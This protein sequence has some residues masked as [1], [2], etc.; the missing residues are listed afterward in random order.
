MNV[1]PS[2]HRPFEKYYDALADLLLFAVAFKRGD[3]IRMIIDFDYRDVAR[4][5]AERAY[6]G[7]ALYVQLDY[8]DQFMQA[9]AIRG[10]P[11]TFW[12]PESRQAKL[13]EVTSPGWKLISIRSEAEGDVFEGLPAER[14]TAFFRAYRDNIAIHSDAVMSNRI[15]WT[16]TYLPSEWVVRKAF[17]NLTPE[18]GMTR[19]WNAIV[20]I[21][22]LDADDPREFWRNE[23][24]AFEKRSTFME[25]LRADALHFS[26]PGTDLTVGLNHSARW[27]GGYDRAQSGEEFLA[28][29]PTGEIFTSPDCRRVNGR[30]KFTRPFVMHQNLGE[31]PMDAWLEFRDGRVVD[32]GASRGKDTLAAFF[33]IDDRARYAG[34]I[35]LVDPAS[36]F[37]ETGIT[38]YNGLYDENSACHLAL[39]RAYP[40]TL[41]EE[42]ERSPDELLGMG[43]NVATVHEDA[44]IGGPEVDVSAI[45]TD[46]TR[47]DIIREGRYLI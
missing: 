22:H 37:A 26:G 46:G 31:V 8:R 10:T 24:A 2:S 14:S 4:R 38:F 9:A 15:P 11:D 20:Q 40:F 21:V 7:G 5:V 18:E 12:F 41:R 28:N 30:V 35:A 29:V 43:M 47:R 33:D 3:K 6:A 13:K 39:G 23:M 44:M 45:L 36:P 19:Y 25:E 16:V 32:F 17:P 27:I 34:E 42:K 1:S